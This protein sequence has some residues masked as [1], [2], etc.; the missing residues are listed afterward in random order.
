[1]ILQGKNQLGLI[2]DFIFC[3]ISELQFLF[4]LLMPTQP[5]C[6]HAQPLQS[7]P[8][9]CDPMDRS[10]SGYS[11]HRILQEKILE[12]VAMPSF[13]GSSRSRNQTCISCFAGGF[14]TTEP[15]GKPSIATNFPLLAQKSTISSTVDFGPKA[16][17]FRYCS[18]RGT[19]ILT[20]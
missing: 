6:V 9:L 14:F 3:F 18:K 20:L 12:W 10:S 17:R 2:P 15:P 16:F 7:C 11:V 8:V 5:L 19:K 1:M 13:R 4:P